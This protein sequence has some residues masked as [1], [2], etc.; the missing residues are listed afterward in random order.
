M[1]TPNLHKNRRPPPSH[2]PTPLPTLLLHIRR[3]TF[4]SPPPLTIMASIITA[5]ADDSGFESRRKGA[6][7]R[8]RLT[9][10]DAGYKD[11]LLSSGATV[12]ERLARSP[13]TKANWI[14]SPAGSPDFHKWESCRT[15]PLVSGSSRGSPVSHA[16]SFQ[17]HSFFTHSLTF[18]KPADR[19][20][21]FFEHRYHASELGATSH[22]AYQGGLRRPCCYGTRSPYWIFVTLDL[23][24]VL[25]EGERGG[26]SCGWLMARD[27]LLRVIEGEFRG[28][29]M[30]IV[31]NHNMAASFRLDKRGGWLVAPMHDTCPPKEDNPTTYLLCDMKHRVLNTATLLHYKSMGG[32]PLGE[33]T[34][35]A[36]LAGDAFCCFCCVARWTRLPARQHAQPCCL[37]QLPGI[38]GKFGEQPVCCSVQEHSQRDTS[39]IQSNESVEAKLWSHPDRSIVREK[40]YQ[41]RHEPS[42]S[43]EA[44]HH[45]AQKEHLGDTRAT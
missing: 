15:M 10:R 35:R 14:Q 23:E 16:P 8:S 32:N 33:S 13:P 37:A 9:N 44:A 2:C 24:P 30:V 4:A 31:W 43:N 38:K 6:K 36:E 11:N 41:D 27:E 40:L 28:S 12:A 25:R 17:R 42:N 22:L 21:S 29:N 45:L 1:P 20:L 5:S 18:F 34:T 26:E 39:K 3:A 19:R 7:N